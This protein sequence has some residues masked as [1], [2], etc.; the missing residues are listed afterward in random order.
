MKEELIKNLNLPNYE[1]F[2]IDQNLVYR[3]NKINING[4]EIYFPYEVYDN[5]KKYMENIIQLLNSRIN[6][7]RTNIA[8]LE[9]PTGTGKTLCL[10]CSTLAWMNEMRRQKKYGG[11][12]IYTTRTHSQIS[13]VMRELRKTCYKP[14]T[15]V[16]ASRD[17]SCVNSDIRKNISGNILNIKCRKN[18]VKCA[19]Y[20]GVLSDKREK[21]NMLDI[22]ELFKN[23]KEQTFCPFYQQIE[24]AKSYSDIVFM[25]YN[26]IFD[27]DISKIMEIN[28][29]NDI[30]IIDEAHNIRRVC[31]DSKSIEI[32]NTDFDDI[33]SDLDAFLKLDENEELISNFFQLK[34]KNKKKELL[35]S[36]IP[37]EDIKEEKKAIQKIKDKIDEFQIMSNHSKG[38]KLTFNEFFDLF[39]SKDENS[40][41]KKKKIVKKEHKDDEL[42]CD[43]NSYISINISDSITS[44]NLEEHISFLELL[45]KNFQEIFEKGTKISILIKILNMINQLMLNIILKKNYIFYMEEKIKEKINEETKETKIEKIKNFYIFCFSPHLGFSDILNS[46][47]YSIIFTSGTLSPFKLYENELQIKFDIA[48]E[49]KHIIP[50]EQINFNILS[51]YEGGIYRFDYNNRKDI[52]M[53]K[54]LGNE[55]VNYCKQVQTGG[56]LV[57]F[58]SFYYLNECKKVWDNCGIRKEIEKYKKLYID[59]SKDKNSMKQIKDNYNNNYIFFSVHRGIASEGIDYSDDSARAVI[60]IGIPFADISDNRVK[61]KIEY[62]NSL[63]KDDKNLISGYEWYDADAMT[64]V[65][66]SLG[67]VIRHKNDFGTM[68]CID[69]RYIQYEKYFSFW[70]RDYYEKHRNNSPIKVNDFLK[71]QREKFIDIIEE[72]KKKS[73]QSNSNNNQ[74]GFNST[75]NFDKIL[76][77]GIK[78]NHKEIKYEIEED[79]DDEFDEED[80]DNEYMEEDENNVFK[81]NDILI[82]SSNEKDNSINPIKNNS[83][84]FPRI[85][86]DKINTISIKEIGYK[87]NYN[88]IL[89][90]IKHIKAE[91]E[92]NNDIYEEYKVSNNTNKKTDDI[93][94]KEEKQGKQLLESLKAFL[95]NNKKEFNNILNKYK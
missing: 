60:C 7:N 74:S 23:G 47:P 26:Y 14:R 94:E 66:Q 83:F 24:I 12:I 21:N 65:N 58:T 39:L 53:I 5:Q 35:K 76:F 72:N 30:I 89:E 63:R 75:I 46:N 42:S 4:I 77:P 2:E 50:N 95:I 51:N 44:S 10:L 87:N 15:A 32:K 38:Q 85:N 28:I 49:N 16:L 90:E 54:A 48:F 92:K 34:P 88:D 11:K 67:R 79:D 78:K 59:S 29:T 71:E 57:F 1:P 80:N 27:E 82:N 91:N 62:L 68:L 33:F 17:R 81:E 64:A 84:K 40:N 41:I 6:L 61:L 36:E 22:E 56:I 69:E 55:I 25:P 20:N 8:A 31:E 45:N 18:C 86:E 73:Y 37:K 70:I 19:Y 3:Q 93:F 43:S 52:K 13:Q 9:S